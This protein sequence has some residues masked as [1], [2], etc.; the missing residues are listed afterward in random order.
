M[1]QPAVTLN[2]CYR[3]ILRKETLRAQSSRHPENHDEAS[4]SF[5]LPPT[6]RRRGTL[7][8]D[9]CAPAKHEMTVNRSP[10]T[11]VTAPSICRR[12]SVRWIWGRPFAAAQ[13][14][15]KFG[16]KT[17]GRSKCAGALPRRKLASM[18]RRPLSVLR[19]LFHRQEEIIRLW[20]DGI[21]QNWLVGNEGVFSCNPPHRS[22]EL[23]E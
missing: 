19:Q 16:V 1:T 18:P 11:V 2:R 13:C 17:Q 7:C 21:F 22:V 20:K 6:T 10:R 9:I 3:S 8:V 15:C 12:F 5:S 23:V 4:K 14:R